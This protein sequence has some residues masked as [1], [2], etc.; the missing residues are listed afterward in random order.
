MARA[1]RNWCMCMWMLIL[2]SLVKRTHGIRF[3]LDKKECWVH[4]VAD[5]GELLHVSFVVIKVD[6]PWAF[7]HLGV[8]VVV[9]LRPIYP[10]KLTIKRFA[11]LHAQ[12]LCPLPNFYDLTK[13]FSINIA[14][15]ERI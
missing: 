10:Q 9:S 8:D 11:V 1:V 3:E 2:V 15:R 5:D 6:N 4:Q 7:R 14:N 13:P 12:L